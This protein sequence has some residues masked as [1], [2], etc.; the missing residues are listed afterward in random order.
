VYRAVH[1][2]SSMNLGPIRFVADWVRFVANFG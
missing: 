2:A 1:Q